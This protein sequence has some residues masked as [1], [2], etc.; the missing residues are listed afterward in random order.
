MLVHG[1]CDDLILSHWHFPNAKIPV[2]PVFA[3][4]KPRAFV[5]HTGTNSTYIERYPPIFYLYLPLFC[6]DMSK[7]EILPLF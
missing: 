5:S 6:K 1:A 7:E 2:S 4:A 3:F